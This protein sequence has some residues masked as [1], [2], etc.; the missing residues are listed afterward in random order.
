MQVRADIA[1]EVPLFSLDT[2]NGGLIIETPE[3]D[4]KYTVSIAAEDT[5]GI[6]PDHEMIVGLYDLFLILG[7]VKMLQQY[8]KVRI[9]PSVTRE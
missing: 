9:Y 8:G 3:T 7:D 1:D 6:C 5:E 4:G 2:E